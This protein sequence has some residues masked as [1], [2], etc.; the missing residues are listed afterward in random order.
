[1][2]RLY[3]II[4]LSRI[5]GKILRL[6]NVFWYN[7]WVVYCFLWLCGV[8]TVITADIAILF[9]AFPYDYSAGTERGCPHKTTAL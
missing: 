4:Q 2:P 1:M 9:F 8:G 3:N 7:R 6:Q 5:C